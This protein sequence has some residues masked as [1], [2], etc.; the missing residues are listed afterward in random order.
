MTKSKIPLKAGKLFIFVTL[1]LISYPSNAQ[2]LKTNPDS[3]PFAPAVNY[4]VGDGPNSVFCA[5]LDGDGDLDLAIANYASDNVSILKNNGEGTFQ[6]K[7]D[8]PTGDNPNSVFC[9]DLD[10]DSDLDLAVPN[11]FSHS[12]SIFKNNGFGDFADRVDYAAAPWPWSVFCADLDGDSD[13]DL[14]VPHHHPSQGGPYYISILKNNGN[15]T[16]QDGVSYF[17]G[18][19]PS[20][21]FCAD[22]DADSSLD[23]AV[24]VAWDFKV[25]IFKN[26]G[27]G[28]F[29][30]RDDYGT[31]YWS[32]PWSVF[33]ADL[34]GDTDLD[35]AVANRGSANVSILKNNGD[36]TF[37]SLANYGV[38]AYPGSVFCGDL[39]GDSDLDL[40]VANNG[41][42]YVSILKN[43]GDGTF[44][45][46]VDYTVDD[47]PVS[48]FCA[49][50]DGDGDLDLA[51][52]NSDSDNVSILKNLSDQPILGTIAGRIKD[53]NTQQN[54]EG[55][56]V[57]A[58]QGD[59]VKGS[60]NT[61]NSG[62]YSI[63]NLPSGIYDIRAS[64]SGYETQTQTGK[65]VFA[66][67]TTT[68]NFNLSLSPFYFVHITDLHVNYDSPLHPYGTHR[69]LEAINSIAN[70][71]NPPDFVLCTGDLVDYSF[72]QS[73]YYNWEFLLNPLHKRNGI[74]Y[75]DAN[76]KIP[77]YFCPGNH[78]AADKDFYC[79]MNFDQYHENIGPDYYWIQHKNC[80]I[81]S[82]NSGKDLVWPM[83][84]PG[85]WGDGLSDQYGNEVTNLPRDLDALDGQNNGMDNS[86]YYKIIMMH[87]PYMNP[88]W[89]VYPYPET[90]WNARDPFVNACVDYGVNLFLCGHIH[91]GGKWDARNRYAE[92]WH[93]GDGT[94][95]V[96]TNALTESFSYRQIFITPGTGLLEVGPMRY[97]GSTICFAIDC[98]AAVHVYDQNGNHDGPNG[99]G[100]I[101]ILIPGST[102]S[103]WV[104]DTL[105]M[106]PV[107]TEF[108][109]YK[110]D[111]ANYSFVIEGLTDDT[112]NLVASTYIKDG[113]WSEAQYDSVPI[114]QGSVATLN[115][116]CSILDYTMTI[117]DPDSS[118]REVT[119]SNW[120]GNLP[121]VEPTAP[122]GPTMVVSADSSAYRTSST[123]PE[124]DQ[125]FYMFD[126]GDS[127]NSGWQGPFASGDTCAGYHRWTESG[128][129]NV[130]VRAIDNW[131]H[132]SA[133]SDPLSVIVRARGDANGD[134]ILDVG[135]VV[136][137]INYLFKSGPAPIPLDA[138]D[139][140]CDGIVDIGDVVYLINYLF[141]GGPPPGC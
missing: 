136:Y 78:D 69:W 73:A 131:D 141:K 35:L 2:I 80:I 133:W 98:E 28:G 111:T 52:A 94:P 45:T 50:L 63:P 101:E 43:N 12:I 65:Y 8:Y 72:G 51:V 1:L 76:Y 82:M 19:A 48:V 99:K 89:P 53:A 38:G 103:R 37:D 11:R 83:P 123:D 5:D 10:G 126:W 112:M 90:F 100:D 137:L 49:D 113:V 30:T 31:G 70:W 93:E 33:C 32:V 121:P 132:M 92:P 3:I 39:D 34:D 15:G 140:N 16:F 102:Y 66:G 61:N 109:V 60:D 68:Q 107:Y 116:N 26:D 13:L 55:V 27:N 118:V 25:S 85:P 6:A 104:G 97:F 40:A 44:Q 122:S 54:L 20:R 114:Y 135:D 17:A 42:P 24:S 57:E 46:K 96:I 59:I 62:Q 106:S 4:G 88:I 91:D 56:L 87:H 77:I 84:I 108:S 36:G 130:R 7:V 74:F 58:L 124:N 127:T 117:L 110:E 9:A 81:F 29:P 21:V 129:H 119:P 134:G 79:P 138:G 18:N 71:P 67:Q 120:Q 125:V 23:L 41:I 47:S 22:L 95:F 128:T 86:N 139:A 115:A 105:T 14:A 75:I 64:K